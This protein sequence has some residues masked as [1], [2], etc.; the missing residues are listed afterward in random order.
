MSEAVANEKNNAKGSKSHSSTK[1]S[2]EWVVWVNSQGYG[3]QM[4]LMVPLLAAIRLM[5]ASI[6]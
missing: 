4:A 6:C 2:E 5:T 1:T 3:N